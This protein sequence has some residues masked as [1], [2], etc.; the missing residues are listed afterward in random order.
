A[1]P[2]HVLRGPYRPERRDRVRHAPGGRVRAG[3]ARSGAV[4][5]ASHDQAPAHA[6]QVRRWLRMISYVGFCCAEDFVAQVQACIDQA[7]GIET[8]QQGKVIAPTAEQ[9]GIHYRKLSTLL[10][11]AVDQYTA[12]HGEPDADHAVG[13]AEWLLRNLRG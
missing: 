3:Q 10:Q 12:Q 7:V 4:Q 11:A 5:S 13:A 1:H 6:S 2:G 8:L 9:W